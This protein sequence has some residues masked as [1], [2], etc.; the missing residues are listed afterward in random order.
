MVP[1]LGR[2]DLVDEGRTGADADDLEVAAPVPVELGD[3][4]FEVLVGIVL[5]PEGIQHDGHP[6]IGIEDRLDVHFSQQ[7][8]CAGLV[9]LSVRID[10]ESRG[11]IVRTALGIGGS[12]INLRTGGPL[13]QDHILRFRLASAGLGDGD[14]P[15]KDGSQDKQYNAF[16]VYCVIRL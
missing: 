10:V 5:G 6:V 11:E 4:G 16:H 8:F 7:G 2:D 12:A 1:R 15:E 9:K 13:G 3:K 14:R